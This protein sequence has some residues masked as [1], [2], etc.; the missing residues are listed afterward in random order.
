LTE[1]GRTGEQHCTVSERSSIQGQYP[2]GFIGTSQGMET[3]ILT[4][5]GDR[6]TELDRGKV[7]FFCHDKDNHAMVVLR[8]LL[9]WDL[10]EKFDSNHVVKT[11]KTLFQNDKWIDRPVT[12]SLKARRRKD[13]L[14]ILESHLLRWFHVVVKTNAPL[15]ERQ[16]MWL[17]AFDH[18]VHPESRSE[19]EGGFDWKDR[20][21]EPYQAQLRKFLD[22]AVKLIEQI[23]SEISTQLNESLHAIKAK[24]ADKTYAWKG[25]WQARCAVAA[26]IMNEGHEWKLRCHQDLGFAPLSPACQATVEAH[27]KTAS[28]DS[29]RRAASSYQIETKTQRRERKIERSQEV[30]AAKKKKAILHDP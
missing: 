4:K 19:G 21:K 5:I 30:A 9:H 26:L 23:Q 10:I 6:W 7:R 20:A 2:G 8:D 15:E 14:G 16:R 28:K 25:S 24:M 22:E 12:D 13:A 29:E 27:N 17:A 11:W 18:Y 1:V 3:A